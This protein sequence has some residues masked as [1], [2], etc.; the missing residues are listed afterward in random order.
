MYSFLLDDDEKKSVAYPPKPAA[1]TTPTPAPAV[2]APAPAVTTPAVTTPAPAVKDE[3]PA[4]LQRKTAD[5][6]PQTPWTPKEQ[7]VEAPVVEKEKPSL[8]IPPISDYDNFSELVKQYT[9]TP[10]TE[11]EQ[12]RRERGAAAAQS[13]GALGNVLSAF[14]NLAFTGGVAPSQKLPD[15]PDANK[16]VQA[17][18][19]QVEKSRQAYLNNLLQGRALQQKG[20]ELGLKRADLVRKVN[21]EDKR[22]EIQD[23]LTNA[24]I[25]RMQAATAKD[26]ASRKKLEQEADNLVALAQKKLQLMDSQIGLNNQRASHV[27][28]VGS[29]A[30]RVPHDVANPLT[31]ELDRLYITPNEEIRQ[32]ALEMGDDS[33]TRETEHVNE[34]G[35]KST[36]KIERGKSG[37]QKLAELTRKKKEERK[38][39][40]EAKKK[41]KTEKKPN[42]NMSHTRALGL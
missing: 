16:D 29:G 39:A 1:A 18:R 21:A 10:M 22:W 12:K 5:Y 40:E 33:R 4:A 42:N 37:E 35:G 36:T 2:A 11:E 23:M 32:R 41:A 28:S 38:A 14:S 6:T 17:F 27:G 25:K 3:V 30:Y 34:F 8:E 20:E 15:L 7:R 19:T 13:M 9:S 26:D 31:G 24:K